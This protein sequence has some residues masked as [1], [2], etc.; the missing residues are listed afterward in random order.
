MAHTNRSLQRGDDE[1]KIEKNVATSLEPS[2]KVACPTDFFRL[3]VR[4][5]DSK[6]Q[7]AKLRDH[8][9]HTMAD[10]A[11]AAKISALFSKERHPFPDLL[12]AANDEHDRLADAYFPDVLG[13]LFGAPVSDHLPVLL[14]QDLEAA[15]AESTALRQHSLSG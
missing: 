3:L 12:G 14:P 10:P 15:C 2:P 9:L 4:P 1:A 8:L 7:I 5:G 6:E 13:P 11:Y